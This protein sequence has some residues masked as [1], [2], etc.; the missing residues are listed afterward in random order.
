MPEFRPFAGIRYDISRLPGG[1]GAVAAPPYDVIDE[2]HRVA[3][4]AADPHNSV[5]LILPRD[6]PGRDRYRAAAETMTTW[7]D[8]GIL[9]PDDAPRFYGYGMDFEDEDG[10]PRHTHGVIG[11]LALPPPGTTTVLP[12]ERTMPKVKSDR[13]ALLR[14]TRTN[15]D[16]IWC[17][18]PSAG[19]SELL[20]SPRAALATS[21]DAD[22]V[23]HRLVAIDASNEIAA[24]GEQVAGAP[25]V[26]A[27]GHH[28]FETACTYRDERAAAGHDDPGAGHIMAFVVELSEDELCVR[29][30][31]R[32]LTG[33]DGV[34]AR[35]ALADAFEVASAGPNEPE[36]LDALT[37]RMRDEDGLGLVDR[38]GL[39]LLRP[40]PH[41]L[42]AHL[43]GVE[44]PV[45]GV[46][47]T[48]FDTGILPSLPATVEVGYRNDAA[49]VAAL[50]EKGTADAA[51][52]LRPV[53]VG[54]IRDAA[55][56]GLRMPEKTTFFHPK[57][58]TGMVF[59]SL[60]R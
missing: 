42:A 60:D 15:L 10:R 9:V 5:R 23:R 47:A 49:A 31:H 26:I 36:E 19:L 3:L 56:A 59:R 14:A 40:R 45:R 18:S 8:E 24:L 17:L 16:P 46:D 54:Q 51:V 43:A 12:H 25:I 48:M 39:A 52:L 29:P 33:L 1:G 34:D 27:D 58:R 13:L 35:D 4:E 41:A 38:A 22:G 11:G 44:E 2:D 7:L 6:I 55:F 28:R 53:T 21:L 37:H 20:A 57:P 50:V 32:V 30:I